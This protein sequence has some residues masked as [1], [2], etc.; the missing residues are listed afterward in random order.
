M[1]AAK[2]VMGFAIVNLIILFTK[3]AFT[4]VNIGLS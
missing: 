2:L 3:I 4:V 1:F